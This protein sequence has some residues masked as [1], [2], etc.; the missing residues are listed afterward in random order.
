MCIRDSTLDNLQTN[1]KSVGQNLSDILFQISTGQNSVSVT[2]SSATARDVHSDHTFADLGSVAAGWGLTTSG[3]ALHLDGLNGT[4][5]PEHTIIGVP[6]GSSYSNANSSI[7][8]NG[9]HN[10]FLANSVTF[11]LSVP[12]V[13]ASSTI[14]SATF[15]FGTTTGDNHVGI[16]TIP[17]PEPSSLV[18]AVFGFAGLAAWSWR[19]AASTNARRWVGRRSLGAST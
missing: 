14:S 12:G 18:L 15:S 13:T 5:T 16:P 4:N 19:R 10:P 6:N 11:V 1:E 3:A 9:P 8:G 7:A 2:S 17:T